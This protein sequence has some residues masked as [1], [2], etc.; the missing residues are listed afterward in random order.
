[1]FRRF[2]QFFFFIFSE[3]A[4]S[5]PPGLRGPITVLPQPRSQDFFPFLNLRKFKK[6]KKSWERGW[7][8]PDHKRPTPGPALILLSLETIYRA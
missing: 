7:V 6:G 4:A 8:L 3:S 1:V 2:L 5:T